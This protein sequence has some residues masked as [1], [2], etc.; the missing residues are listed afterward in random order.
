MI[1]SVFIAVD[2]L[3]KTP[4]GK[5]DRL[6]LPLPNRERPEMD[7]P[8]IPPRNAIEIEMAAIWSEVFDLDRVGIHDHF[9]DLGGHSLLATRIIARVV[10]RFK[11]ELPMKIFLEAPTVAQTAE[12][13]LIELAKT[14]GGQDLLREIDTLSDDELAAVSD[15]KTSRSRHRV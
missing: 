10:E 14:S 2:E 13:L 6:R 3:P 4:N 12:I 1:P 8:F 5:T 7:H 9:L 11:V 15:Q